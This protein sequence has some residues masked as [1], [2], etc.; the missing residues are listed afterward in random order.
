MTIQVTYLCDRIDC[1]AQEDVLAS[2][3]DWPHADD[4]ELPEGWGVDQHGLD[5]VLHCPTHR[6]S[7]QQETSGGASRNED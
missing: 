1:D 7:Q 4:L 6:T 5:A 3:F 2:Q